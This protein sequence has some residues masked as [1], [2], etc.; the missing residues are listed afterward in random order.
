MWPGTWAC[1]RKGVTA[2]GRFL[3][4]TQV[5]QALNG[6]ER[7]ISI[8]AVVH[9]SKSG[10]SMSA[11]PPIADIAECH[12]N[13]RFTPTKAD[14]RRHECDVRFVPKPDIRGAAY[15]FM[16]YSIVRALGRRAEAQ[17]AKAESTRR[18]LR[19]AES[20]RRDRRH[21]PSC[22]TVLALSRPHR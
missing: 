5:S 3:L 7:T 19:P 21:R 20:C 9:H 10:R 13:V 12:L 1:C 8:E 14:I 2:S 6:L 11:L 22:R 15:A 4:N 16:R 17:R 18:P